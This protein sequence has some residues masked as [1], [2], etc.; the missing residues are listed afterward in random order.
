[1]TTFNERERAFETK[2][3]HDAEMQFKA[4]ARASRLLGTWAAGEMGLMGE[5]A[6]AYVQAAIKA[7]LE[8]PGQEDLFRKVWADL[9]AK[10]IPI[11]EAGLRAKMAA[12]LAEA[13][14]Q[15]LGE[16]GE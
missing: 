5:D 1:M 14:A 4:E 16:A 2:F 10:A 8:E 9:Q 15:L 3:A 7:D 12:C 6:E 13:K 11:D